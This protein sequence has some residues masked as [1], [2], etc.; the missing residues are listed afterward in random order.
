M[1][2]VPTGIGRRWRTEER[3]ERW[4]E[5]GWERESTRVQN[6]SDESTR[7]SLILLTGTMSPVHINTLDGSILMSR[8]TL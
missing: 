2:V 6:L 7:A 1:A 8:N 5:R 4:E 3:K